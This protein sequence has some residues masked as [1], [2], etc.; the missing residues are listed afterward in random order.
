MI[1]PENNKSFAWRIFNA[2]FVIAAAILAISAV[3][4]QGTVKALGKRYMKE[5]V[6]LRRSIRGFDASQLATF[7]DWKYSSRSKIPTK[8]QITELE[9]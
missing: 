4:M 1:R 2:K 9:G 8:I 5:S 7:K 3:G 6:D